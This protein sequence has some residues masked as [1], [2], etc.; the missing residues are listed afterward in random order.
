ME[1]HLEMG[2]GFHSN[3][4]WVSN[5]ERDAG[6]R[7][8]SVVMARPDLGFGSRMMLAVT[9]IW[10]KAPLIEEITCCITGNYC[11]FMVKTIR[12]SKTNI[13]TSVFYYLFSYISSNYMDI[14]IYNGI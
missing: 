8:R 11:F 2:H 13:I 10:L 12:N 7:I 5:S 1:N 6:A 9:K 3:V 14:Y 4:R